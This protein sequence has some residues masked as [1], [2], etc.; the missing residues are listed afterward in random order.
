[1]SWDTSQHGH[2]SLPLKTECGYY[3]FSQH[4]QNGIHIFC[5]S[6]SQ[7]YNSRS[8][9]GT[10]GGLSPSHLCVCVF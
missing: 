7:A 6:E 5:L 3:W 8:G 10:A 9:L 1:M 4:G 2:T